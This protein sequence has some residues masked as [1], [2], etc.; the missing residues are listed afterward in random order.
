M[1]RRRIIA[2]VILLA[3]V[4]VAVPFGPGVWRQAKLRR[5]VERYPGGGALIKHV[6]RFGDHQGQAE[7]FVWRRYPAGNVDCWEHK[8]GQMAPGS[9]FTQWSASGE[10][11]KQLRHPRFEGDPPGFRDSPPWWPHPPLID[12]SEFEE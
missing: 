6:W 12:L 5:V 1:T 2:G 9:F 10:V 4:A 8:D 7:G 11:Y 3:A